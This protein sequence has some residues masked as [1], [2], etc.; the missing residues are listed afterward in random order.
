V[1]V[2]AEQ[3]GINSVIYYI[4]PHLRQG[5]ALMLPYNTFSGV[6]FERGRRPYKKGTILYEEYLWSIREVNDPV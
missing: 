2:A 1:V 3:S 5:N 4:D 6:R